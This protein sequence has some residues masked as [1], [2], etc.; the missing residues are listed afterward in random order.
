MFPLNSK[1]LIVD[2]MKGIRIWL[3]KSLNIL[4]YTDLKEA[5]NGEEALELL[6]QE[7]FDLVFLDIVMP[8]MDGIALLK[9][10]KADGHFNSLPIIILS[11]ET[12]GQLITEV[13]G[14]GISQYI[15]K[16]ATIPV[17]QKKMGDVFLAKK[18]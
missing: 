12:D 7:K 11:A 13:I 1:I 5:S 17:L 16:P 14:L 18:A 2:D 4:G 6:K 3:Q 15:I 8:K 9:K 10:L